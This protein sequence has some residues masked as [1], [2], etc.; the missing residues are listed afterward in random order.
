[1]GLEVRR[2]KH[3]YAVFEGGTRISQMWQNQRDAEDG[4]DKVQRRRKGKKKRK[5]LTCPTEIDSEG[6]HHRMCDHC[7]RFGAS[8][9]NQMAN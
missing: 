1:M 9:S 5:C 7:R 3:G 6:P 4:M 2:Y 8:L